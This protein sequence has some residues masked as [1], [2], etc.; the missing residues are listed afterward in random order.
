MDYGFDF[1]FTKTFSE[2]FKELT[3]KVPKCNLLTDY[4]KLERSDFVHLA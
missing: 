4:N 1:D 2:N 3:L